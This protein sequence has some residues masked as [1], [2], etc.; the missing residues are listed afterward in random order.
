[1]KPGNI[2]II[3]LIIIIPF[4]FI[5]DMK[6]NALTALYNN[7]MELDKCFE[8]A[9]DDGISGLVEVDKNRQIILHKQNAIDQFYN[10]L[11]SN[12]S[13]VGNNNFTNLLKIYIPIIL[14]TDNDGFYIFYSTTEINDGDKILVQNFSE[15]TAYLYEDEHYIYNFTLNDYIY[16][17]NNKGFKISEGQFKDIISYLN[18]S[19]LNYENYY[20]I[21]NNTITNIIEKEMNHYIK[22]HNHIAKQFGIEYEFWLPEIDQDDWYRTVG[23]IS[24]MVIMQGYPFDMVGNR[25][26]RI[27]ITGSRIKKRTM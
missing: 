13:V 22:E 17:Y 4:I 26:N 12:L 8:S 3:F 15:K 25:Y 9:L 6:I 2:S 20:E 1:M 14:I 5:Q 24:L 23:D 7:K 21:K 19:S 11:Y 27:G 16:I 10:S 18:N